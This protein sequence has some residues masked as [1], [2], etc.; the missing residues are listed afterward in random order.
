MN[1]TLLCES[2]VLN[3]S[4][5]N[6]EFKKVCIDEPS[7]VSQVALKVTRKLPNIRGLLQ[8]FKTMEEI[9]AKGAQEL[10]TITL[11]TANLLINL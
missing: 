2:E 11:I 7:R 1:P 8:L 6:H 9:C 3:Q 10:I 4:L 5:C